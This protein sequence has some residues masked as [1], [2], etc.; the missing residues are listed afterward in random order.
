VSVNDVLF[1][2]GVD[3]NIICVVL[4]RHCFL[5]SPF[6][7]LFLYLGQLRSWD[8]LFLHHVERTVEVLLLYPSANFFH[9][10]PQRVVRFHHLE[11]GLDLEPEISLLSIDQ[12]IPKGLSIVLEEETFEVFFV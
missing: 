6:L 5:L 1:D 3:V 12:I 2:L 8:H 10:V 7:V 9:L 11:L 4:E